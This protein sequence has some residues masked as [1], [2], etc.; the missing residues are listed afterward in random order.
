MGQ[1]R[2]EVRGEHDGSDEHQ[3]GGATAQAPGL[4]GAQRALD[5]IGEPA[6]SHQRVPSLGRLAQGPVQGERGGHREGWE[7]G[8]QWLA[9]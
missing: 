2:E 5:A 7:K 4:P 3:H 8:G 1:P 6:E 9:P